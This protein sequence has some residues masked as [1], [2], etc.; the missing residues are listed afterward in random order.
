VSAV[1][2]AELLASPKNA[3]M[4]RRG[5]SQISSAALRDAAVAAS[6]DTTTALMAIPAAVFS[7][8]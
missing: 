4:A 8:F 6:P 7:L 3:D 2:P 1:E 5:P